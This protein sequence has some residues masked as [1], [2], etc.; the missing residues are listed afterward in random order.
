MTGKCEKCFRLTLL[1]TKRALPFSAL[2]CRLG[3]AQ[4]SGCV[5]HL[6]CSTQKLVEWSLRYSVYIQLQILLHRGC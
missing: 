1:K 5:L 4:P 3:H 6:L 2:W